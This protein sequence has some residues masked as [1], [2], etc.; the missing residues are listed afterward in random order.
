MI[1]LTAFSFLSL[2]TAKFTKQRFL[3]KYVKATPA[4]ATTA[5]VQCTIATMEDKLSLM[6]EGGKEVTKE[7]KELLYNRVEELK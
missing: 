6:E 5:G 3:R 2:L 4:L 1:I 7:Q